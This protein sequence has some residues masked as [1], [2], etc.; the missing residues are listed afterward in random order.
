M[1]KK[2]SCSSHHQPDDGDPRPPQIH[3]ETVPA[4]ARPPPAPAPGRSSAMHPAPPRRS[5]A[6]RGPHTWPSSR[7]PGGLHGY[8]YIHDYIY[9]Y[10]YI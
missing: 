2:N 6:G 5:A 10:D 4:V 3:N 7:R 1:W 8:I 9:I